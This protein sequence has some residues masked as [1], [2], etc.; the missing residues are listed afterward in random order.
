M[1]KY[2]YGVDV[3]EGSLEIEEST[4]KDNGVDFIIPR[5]N[6]MN[7][8]H[9]VDSGFSKQWAEAENFIRWPY[10]VY[11]PWVN[12][13]AN[14]EFMAKCMPDCG[15]VSADI[16]VR[17]A[18]YSPVTYANEV[19][20]FLKL[21]AAE[22]NVNIYTGGWFLSYLSAWPTDCEYWWAQYPYV[23]Y[24][25]RKICV[26]WELLLG[27][28]E[29]LQFF[30][31]K[32]PGPCRL[33]Q[34]TADRYVLPGCANRPI[35]INVW[36]GTLQELKDWVQGK[37]IKKIYLPIASW[38]AEIDAWAR[39]MGYAGPRPAADVVYQLKQLASQLPEVG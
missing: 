17:Y 3:W 14:F 20:A 33:R 21:A 24:P 38:A 36:N 26:S 22:W 1:P 29:K 11:N 18:G 12:G 13:K 34:V 32:S 39:S 7:G 5:L 4:L 9:K 8:G 23:L 27:N 35:D 37:K 19:A 10:F 30:P 31:V 16:E 2:V 25:E 28:I 6:N 15:A